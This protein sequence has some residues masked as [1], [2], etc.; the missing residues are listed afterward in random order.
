MKSSINNKILFFSCLEIYTFLYGV[1]CYKYAGEL[2][3]Y[4]GAV[5]ILI[6]LIIGTLIANVKIN[7][8]EVLKHGQ[9]K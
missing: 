4:F 2:G 1:M 8:K 3:V 6:G 5:M 9:S 7:K